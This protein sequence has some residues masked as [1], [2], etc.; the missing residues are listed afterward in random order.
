M[1]QPL[2][3]KIYDAI[4]LS[5]FIEYS[6]SGISTHGDVGFKLAVKSISRRLVAVASDILK[7]VIWFV[8]HVTRR[9]HVYLSVCVC[10]AC[11]TK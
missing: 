5:F 9:V 8:D 6:V 4:V 3:Y 7:C 10:H 11:I 2:L 1:G